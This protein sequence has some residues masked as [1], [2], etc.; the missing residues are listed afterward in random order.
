MRTVTALAVVSGWT[1]YTEH[2]LCY[3]TALVWD[4]IFT[5]SDS[6]CCVTA[7]ALARSLC[8]D[9]QGGAADA[10]IIILCVENTDLEGSPF[11]ALCGPAE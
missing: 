5:R 8:S 1:I 3:V 2:S 10:E 7:L 4:N 9:P 11:R 6:S